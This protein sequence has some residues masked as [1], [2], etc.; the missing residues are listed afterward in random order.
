MGHTGAIRYIYTQNY[1]HGAPP[2]GELNAKPYI[3]G[4]LGGPNF[5]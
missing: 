1:T 2:D 5:A 4:S 3:K